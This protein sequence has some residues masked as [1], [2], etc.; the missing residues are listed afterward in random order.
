[1]DETYLEARRSP[2]AGDIVVYRSEMKAPYLLVKMTDDSFSMGSEPWGVV[3]LYDGEGENGNP[4][5]KVGNL[6]TRYNDESMR[7]NFI[8]LW[9]LREVIE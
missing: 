6:I 9:N 7:R 3:C 2:K 4:G 1:M 5:L 8:P